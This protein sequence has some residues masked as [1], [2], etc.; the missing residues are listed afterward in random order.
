VASPAP[1]RHH[2]AMTATA[3]RTQ[4]LFFDG[5]D[6]LDPI[7]PLE[8]L[9]AAGFPT[10]PVR[11]AGHA[12]AIHTAHG[13]VIEVADVLDGDAELVVIP[14]GGWRDELGGIR[15]LAVGPLPAQLGGMHAQG[16]VL[17]SVCTGAMLLAA[18]GVV[19]GRR[20]V[21]NRIALD[22]LAEAGAEVH[23]EARVV[24]DGDLVSCGGPAAGLDL[25]IH[26]VGRFLGAQAGREAA[27]RLEHEPVGPVLPPPR[28]SV[29]MR[30]KTEVTPSS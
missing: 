25:G 28:V 22:D 7:G 17:A 26:L 20:M 30:P 5:V 6:D 2:E 16:T 23:P 8:V 21:T 9:T 14:G 12:S 27:S 24:D 10:R 15:R 11:P 29:E 3:P 13:L 1:V 19:A 18:A 4:V